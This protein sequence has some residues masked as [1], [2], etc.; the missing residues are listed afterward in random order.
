PLVVMRSAFVKSNG[1]V[2]ALARD[3]DNAA[4]RRAARDRDSTWRAWPRAEA[5]TDGCRLGAP[6]RRGWRLTATL[7]PA[8]LHAALLRCLGQRYEVLTGDRVFVLFPEEFLLHQQVDARRKRVC[9]LALKQRDRVHVL[10]AAEDQFFLL[11][12]LGCVLPHRHRRRHDDGH[13]GDADN[14]CGH[15]VSVVAPARNGFALTR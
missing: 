2:R 6:S 10:L 11:F 7:R 15:G 8:G 14:Q 5:A 3:A 1:A 13:D 12:A 4:S 9:I